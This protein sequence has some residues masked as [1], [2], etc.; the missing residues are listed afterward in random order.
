MKTQPIQIE[1]AL[2]S[3]LSTDLSFMVWFGWAIHV[4]I[5]SDWLW[6]LIIIIIIYSYETLI[7]C[8]QIDSDSWL[9]FLYQEWSQV[10]RGFFQGATGSWLCLFPCSQPGT[11][12][13][14]Q[15]KLWCHTP[16]VAYATSV[17]HQCSFS[18]DCHIWLF[19]SKLSSPNKYRCEWMESWKI[20]MKPLSQFG[21]HGK[22]CMKV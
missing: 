17:L 4:L 9:M 6:L 14:Y 13:E 2:C 8:C 20:K 12:G 11:G 15:S 19:L 18:S 7:S 5:T 22:V 16:Q 21:Y 10:R 3:R 1:S